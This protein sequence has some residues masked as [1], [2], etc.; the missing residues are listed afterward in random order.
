MNGK[1]GLEAFESKISGGADA[2]EE[3][4]FLE[5]SWPHIQ[6]VYELL[7]RLI[8]QPQMDVRV[9]K[10]SITQAYVHRVRRCDV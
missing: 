4:I 1:V 10:N 6:I 3:A 2:D 8:I 5:E 9:L 7:L